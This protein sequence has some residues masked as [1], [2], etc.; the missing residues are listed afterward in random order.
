MNNHYDL[1]DLERYAGESIDAHRYPN[2]VHKFTAKRCPAC[3]VVPFELTIE[4]HSGSKKKNFR[5]VIFGE[6]TQCKS[7]G[8]IFSFTGD[9][10]TPEREEKPVCKCGG[11][12]FLVGECERIERDEGLLG[13]FDEGVVVGKCIECGR[14]R[15]FVFTD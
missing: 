2:D 4:H 8:R 14:N 10:R 1:S 15:A 12:L 13:F 7:K 6:C 9:H 3:G 5:G 11:V